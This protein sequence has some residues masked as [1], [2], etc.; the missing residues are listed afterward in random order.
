MPG[1]VNSTETCPGWPRGGTASE[2]S[3]GDGAAAGLGVLDGFGATLGALDN[4][5]SSSGFTVDCFFG[6]GAVF[7]V[8]RAG[9]AVC[10]GISSAETP[11]RSSRDI[12]GR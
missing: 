4:V 5:G 10:V 7:G 1:S 11:V 8:A 12:V 9:T 2:G 3:H 6:F